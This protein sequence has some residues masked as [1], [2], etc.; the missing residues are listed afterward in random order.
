MP[1][2]EELDDRRHVRA[3]AQPSYEMPLVNPPVSKNT[4]IFR[5][6]ASAA[7]SHVRR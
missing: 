6:E 4:R 1:V 5:A 3:D 7:F 2:G